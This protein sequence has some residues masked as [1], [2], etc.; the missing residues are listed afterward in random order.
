MPNVVSSCALLRRARPSAASWR[1]LCSRLQRRH[2][3]AARAGAHSDRGK[4]GSSRLTRG[5]RRGHSLLYHAAVCVPTAPG[6]IIPAGW[7]AHPADRARHAGG[8]GRSGL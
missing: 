4:E 2:E 7:G 5:L 3:R 1:Q 6:N 8:C